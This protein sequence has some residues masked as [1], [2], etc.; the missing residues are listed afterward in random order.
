MTS[1]GHVIYLLLLTV[2]MQGLTVR[3]AARVKGLPF[4]QLVKGLLLKISL[5]ISVLLLRI[6][7]WQNGNGKNIVH[8][9][10]PSSLALL[11]H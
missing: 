8:Y 7:V 4:S 3:K 1:L 2:Y 9:C 10:C 6:K 11:H 5:D